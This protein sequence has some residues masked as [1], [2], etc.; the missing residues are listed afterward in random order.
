MHSTHI[1]ELP[2]THLPAAVQK[3]HLFPKMG[4]ALLAIPVLC[5]HGCQ[6]IFEASVLVIKNKSTGRTILTGTRDT[7]TGLWIVDIVT[8]SMSHNPA[9]AADPATLTANSAISSE[10]MPE[11]IQVLH[12]ALG[13]LV[14]TNFLDAIENVYYTSIP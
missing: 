6:A 1:G 4:Q 5:N 3:V 7:A 2:L 8:H 11:R 10:T 12:A 13:Y 14:L 9:P